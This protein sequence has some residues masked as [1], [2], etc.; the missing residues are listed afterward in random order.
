ML[1]RISPDGTPVEIAAIV[2]ATQLV[3]PPPPGYVR[4]VQRAYVYDQVPIAGAGLC[5]LYLSAD[6]GGVA[7]DELLDREYV[8]SAAAGLAETCR[9]RLNG[10]ICFREP[11]ALWCGATNAGEAGARYF[12][13]LVRD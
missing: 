2:V 12:D 7:Y 10:P 8:A 5:E 3:P 11:F 6:A 13:M 1:A 4:C 9:A